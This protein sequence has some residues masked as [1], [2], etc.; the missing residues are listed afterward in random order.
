ML[1]AISVEWISMCAQAEGAKIAQKQY[2]NTDQGKHVQRLVRKYGGGRE[3]GRNKYKKA[4]M[5]NVHIS[6]CLIVRSRGNSDS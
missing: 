3:G 5:N 2:E 1:S 4:Y 6:N